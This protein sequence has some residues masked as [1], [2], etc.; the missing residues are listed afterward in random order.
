[1]RIKYNILWVDDRKE[2]F[3]RLGHDKRLTD[4]VSRLFFE[5]HLTMCDNIEEAKA[6]LGSKSFDV[7]F[8]DYNISDSK[9]DEQGNDFIEYVREQNVN[10]EILFYS[11]MEELPP[12]HVNRISF[13]S[14]AGQAGAY[15]ELLSQMEQLI[16]LTVEKLNDLTA[17]RGLVMAETSELDRYMEEICLDYFVA[18][19]SEK[20]DKLFEEIITGMEKDYKNNLKRSENC[21]KKCLHKIRNKENFYDIITGLAFESSRKARTINTLI[22]VEN[23]PL[24]YEFYNTYLKEIINVRN[25]LA[26]SYSYVKDNGVEVLVSKKDGQ[27]IEFSKDDILKIRKDILKYEKLFID[28]K[29]KIKRNL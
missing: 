8:S 10:T 3:K 24:D 23:I 13:F 20:S 5:P 12:I 21:D 4:Y 18:H 11:A 27:D 2:T 15:H 14:F 6:A 22:G 28:I 9:T 7:I 1:M 17:L 29:E 16:D 25:L 26:H 19:K